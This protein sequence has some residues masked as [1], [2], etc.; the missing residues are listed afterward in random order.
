[1]TSTSTTLSRMEHSLDGHSEHPFTGALLRA[2]SHYPRFTSAT[3]HHVNLIHMSH[4]QACDLFWFLLQCSL[5]FK[6][7][8]QQFTNDKAKVAFIISLLSALSL[9]DELFRLRQADMSIHDYT[10]HHPFCTLAACS[11]WNETALLSAF[12]RGLNL[13]LRQQMSIYDDTMGL[14]SFLQK[15]LHVFQHLDA[16]HMEPAPAAA[17]SPISPPPALEEWQ[18]WLE[19]AQHPFEV[20]TDHKNLQ[21]LREAKRLNPRLVVVDHFSKTCKL[22]P[23]KGLLT[24][25]ET[26]EALFYHVFCHF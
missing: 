2:G 25:L 12:H 21:Y 5:Y 22:I 17:A 8:S 14:E 6:L 13:T 19:G 3:F 23:L 26:A 18:H 7:Q 10:I 16:C 24:T 1:K 9:H 15:A 20:V 11:R 4:G